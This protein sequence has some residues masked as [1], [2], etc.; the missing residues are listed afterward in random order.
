[1]ARDQ[2]LRRLRDALLP[3]GPDVASPH[4]VVVAAP[5][6]G[7][8][9]GRGEGGEAFEAAGIALGLAEA[10]ARGG[11]GTLVI[12]ADLRRPSLYRLAGLPLG[13][14]LAEVLSGQ[15]SLDAVIVPGGEP[16][17]FVLPAGAVAL[18]A[19]DADRLLDGP[20]LGRTLSRLA[21]RFEVVAVVAAPLGRFGDALTLGR[22]AEAVVLVPRLHRTQAAA[23]AGAAHEVLLATGRPALAVL[24]GVAED[25][26]TPRQ[27]WKALRK[28]LAW[29]KTV[30]QA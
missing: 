26:L 8:D 6:G 21:E 17:L 13:P 3:A 20:A 18:A 2:G 25:D 9:N 28:R 11:R 1:V 7:G 4:V 14:G 30:R 19:S 5:D 12:D 24:S 10:V 22:L 15:A 29:R 23:L 27:E 16:D